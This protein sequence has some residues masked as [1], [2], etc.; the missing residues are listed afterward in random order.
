MVDLFLRV[1][2]Y[3]W[4]VLWV[5]SPPYIIGI[6]TLARMFKAHCLHTYYT[7]VVIIIVLPLSWLVFHG[8]L[9]HIVSHCPMINTFLYSLFT[10]HWKTQSYDSFFPLT[11]FIQ[12]SKGCLLPF[13]KFHLQLKQRLCFFCNPP[14][15]EILSLFVSL[16]CF[17]GG[18]YLWGVKTHIITLFS[19]H[20]YQYT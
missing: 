16:W 10:A 19:L 14:K 7:T 8:D 11:K 13:A 6:S 3:V 15:I 5:F 9:G 2:K 17:D 18:G 4:M 20:L 1:L 12:Y